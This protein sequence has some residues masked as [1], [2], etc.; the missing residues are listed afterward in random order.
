MIRSRSL[1]IQAP[2]IRCGRR[3][4]ESRKQRQT[5]LIKKVDWEVAAAFFS[6]LF[7]RGRAGPRAW[8]VLAIFECQSLCSLHSR[9]TPPPS[10]FAPPF[11]PSSLLLFLSPSF[12]LLLALSLLLLL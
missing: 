3:S 7:A 5:T 9:L 6:L 10:S 8:L 1:F 12:L 11:F 4:D 2:P